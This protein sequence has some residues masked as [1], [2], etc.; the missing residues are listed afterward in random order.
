MVSLSDLNVKGT[1]I[2]L[3]VDSM[4]HHSQT[5]RNEFGINSS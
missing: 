1:R 4:A 5:A 3:L 2:Q